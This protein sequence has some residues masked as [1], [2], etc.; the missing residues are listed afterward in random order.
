MPRS[1][2]L[3]LAAKFLAR[4][5]GSR[6]LVDDVDLPT[7]PNHP[8]QD[9]EVDWTLAPLDAV[10][11]VYDEKA[12]RGR[13]LN[14][15]HEIEEYG[16]VWEWYPAPD[17]GATRAT[18]IRKTPRDEAQCQAA[19]LETDTQASSSSRPRPRL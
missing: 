17:F 11:W 3:H 4:M 19:H 2:F 18:R 13:W 6:H 14:G 9:I 15:K 10:E 12:R 1:P 5:L 8:L 7:L 16:L